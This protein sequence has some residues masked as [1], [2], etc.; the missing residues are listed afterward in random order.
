MEIVL[1]PDKVSWPDLL[2][3]P[4]ND[5]APLERSVTRIL[6]AVKQRGDTAVRKYTAEFDKAKVRKLE[7]TSKEIRQASSGL[8]PVLKTAILQAAENIRKF[9]SLQKQGGEE[10]ETMP[11]INCRRKAVAIE[12]VGLYIPGG[13]A[14]L[15]STI[16]MLGIPAVIA[17]CKNI[18]LC[19]PPSA[20]G[21]LHPAILF[22]A[23]AVGI[24]KIFKAGGVQAI[25]AMAYGTASIPKVDKIFGPG[26][27]YV[28]L[29]KQMIQQ[30]GVAIDMPAGPSEVCV[31]ADASAEP[32]FIA[33]DLLSQAEHGADS[34]VLLVTTSESLVHNVMRKISEQLKKLPRQSIAEK[35]LANSRAIVIDNMD[36]AMELVNAYAAEHLIIS[37]VDYHKLA[38]QVVNA[39]S[40]FLGN[41]SPESVGDYASGTNHTLP[42]HGYARAY[43][44][45]SVDSFVKKITF[46]ELSREGL[47]NISQTVITMAEHEGLQAH[48]EAV[49][50]RLK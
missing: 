21:S 16:L 13:S 30:D 12:N 18:V 38:D 26:N 5:T 8:D 15:F 4:A 34:Q 27:Q 45:V 41:Y 29:A 3:R 46:Q 36:T 19:S 40:V 23:D 9:H 22:A 31:L 28:T 47:E 48:A 35:A 49:R 25:A 11:G 1:N 44:G 50:Q 39:G 7:V 17:G 2:K 24:K 10:M 6:K 43:S 20:D 37:C 42:T 14:P 32:A 33:S